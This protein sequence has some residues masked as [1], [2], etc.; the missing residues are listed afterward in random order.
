M[1]SLTLSGGGDG[2]L[3]RLAGCHTVGAA[4]ATSVTVACA[5]G[6]TIWGAAWGRACAKRGA[7]QGCCGAGDRCR[8][9][10]GRSAEEFAGRPQ[11]IAAQRAT[12]WTLARRDRRT[13]AATGNFRR[14]I[15]PS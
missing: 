4:V 7:G 11:G 14:R 5:G 3:V 10:G 12:H 9:H 2:G 1:V 13:A 6:I 15:L 8:W